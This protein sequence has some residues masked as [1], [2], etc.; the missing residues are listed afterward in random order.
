MR[1][2][3]EVSCSAALAPHSAVIPA[4]AGIQYAAA[5]VIEPNL[6]GI[7]DRPVK[8]GDDSGKRRTMRREIADGYRS[9]LA[10]DR[11]GATC[12]A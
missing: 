2:E 6:L 5:V 7:L 1:R 8:P 9:Y 11:A 10:N 12:S 3:N 4:K